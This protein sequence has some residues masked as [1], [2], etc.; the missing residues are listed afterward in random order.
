MSSQRVILDLCGGTGAWSQPYTDTG[1]DVVIVDP[2]SDH[3]RAL[4]RDVR[5]L[6]PLFSAGEIHGIL[7][8]PPCTEFAG[9]GAR[10]WA[11]K[12][13]VLL[14]DALSIVSA[15][16]QIID[17]AQPEWWA[18]ENPVGRLGRLM[19]GKPQHSFQPWQYGDP[20]QKRTCLWGSF[21]MPP[22]QYNDPHDVPD[23]DAWDSQAVWLMGPSPER[24]K[25]RSITPPGFARAFHA[26]N[27]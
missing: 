26:A 1:Y 4:R 13:P 18:L 2:F 20:L 22:P 7:A 27:P 19:L 10:W 9:S 12:P 25:L 14:A 23:F 3:P 8:A 11:G 15:C 24:Q 16:I 21:T 17:S 6:P 5:D